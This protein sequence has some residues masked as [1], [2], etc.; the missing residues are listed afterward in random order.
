MCVYIQ[1]CAMTPWP[2]PSRGVKWSN[3]HRI[4]DLFIRP[5]RS[6][7]SSVPAGRPGR[8]VLRVC[9]VYNIYYVCVSV[10]SSRARL[11]YYIYTWKLTFM[12]FRCRC[13]WC[14]RFFS[15]R[16]FVGF[17][18]A[19]VVCEYCHLPRENQRT[20]VNFSFP[21][22]VCLS[23]LWFRIFDL[24]LLRIQIRRSAYDWYLV[25]EYT[26]WFQTY[27]KMQVVF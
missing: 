12:D 20:T 2:P 6:A 8:A 19:G 22:L 24:H 14:R 13:R 17:I 1:H 10:C 3:W 27:N 4:Q 9:D 7:S 15:C 23:H 26:L 16:V 21:L 25:H 18:H 5:I 11:V